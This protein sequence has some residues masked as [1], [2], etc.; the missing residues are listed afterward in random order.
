MTRRKRKK[1]RRLDRRLRPHLLRNQWHMFTPDPDRRARFGQELQRLQPES[2]TFE[3]CW[4]IYQ[5]AV[6][7]GYTSRHGRRLAEK[8]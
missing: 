5:A 8:T 3:D 4:V 6:R 2:T 1:E 7:A